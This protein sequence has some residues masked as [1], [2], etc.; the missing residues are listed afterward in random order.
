[1]ELAK[2]YDTFISRPTSAVVT[3]IQREY[4]IDIMGLKLELSLIPKYLEDAYDNWQAYDCV[5]YDCN[6]DLQFYFIINKNTKE[7]VD[8]EISN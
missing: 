8:L 3:T 1:M 7:L 4:G 2:I 6:L 5:A